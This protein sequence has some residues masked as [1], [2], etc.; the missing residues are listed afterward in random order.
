MET[1]V[2]YLFMV[3]GMKDVE[4]R[5]LKEQIAKMKAEKQNGIPEPVQTAKPD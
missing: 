4:I 3:I 1:T 2:D 5:K